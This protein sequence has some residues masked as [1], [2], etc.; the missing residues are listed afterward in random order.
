M[1]DARTNTIPRHL[2]LILDGNRRWAKAQGLPQLEGHRIGYD[3]LKTIIRAAFKEGVEFVSAYVFST[4]NWQRSKTEV[5]Y[6][7]K[8][9]LYVVIHETDELAKEGICIRFI[10]S[11]T[12]L[13]KKIINAMQRAEARTQNNKQGTVI[14][15]IDYSG[16][17]EIA[18]ASQKIIDKSIKNLRFT[19]ELIEQ[20]L[21]ATDV[22]PVDLIIRTSGEMRLS[23]FML[24]RAA[25]SE[26]LFVD[27][28]W[29]A[30]TVKDLK[31]A[32]KKFA[33]RNRRFGK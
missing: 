6:L 4:E 31:S 1:T 16:H 3:N 9:L 13:S 5:K 27:T 12:R 32:I 17:Q 2:G 28:F 24:W 18:D 20:N 15:L 30:F 26:L 8:L 10:G 21:Y 33:I 11:K 22:P 14:I 25:Y 29:P 23:N 7:M 19:P